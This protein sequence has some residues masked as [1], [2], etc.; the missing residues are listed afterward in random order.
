MLS[1]DIGL[2]RIEPTVGLNTQVATDKYTI[3]DI[4][5]HD[6]FKNISQIFHSLNELEEKLSP[7]IVDVPQIAQQSIDESVSTPGSPLTV[8]LKRTASE[9]SSINLKLHSIINKIDL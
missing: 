3:V 2:K 8:K 9:L 4:V 7:I 5:D 1:N 6:I